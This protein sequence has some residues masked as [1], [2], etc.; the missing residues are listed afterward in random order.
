MTTAAS[1]VNAELYAGH[2]AE[3]QARY[4]EA[5]VR[6]DLDAVV[7]G[8]G[9]PLYRFLDDQPYRYVAN[10]L[11]RHWVPLEEHPGSAIVCKPGCRP[12]LIVHQPLDFW[13][14]PPPLPD[15]AVAS[16]FELRIMR[17]V[18]EL[19]DLLPAADGNRLALLGAA[20]QWEGIAPEALRNPPALLDYLHYH[21]ARKS[22][23]ELGCLRAA[24]A[25][26]TAGHQAAEEAFYGGGSEFDILFAF[27]RGCGQTEEELPYGLIVALDEHGA[28]LHYQ[29]R[30]RTRPPAGKGLSLLIDAGCSHLGYASDITRSHARHDGEF[31][32]MV[33][34]MTTLQRE[35]CNAVRPGVPFADLH[36]FAH[37]GIAGLLRQWGIVRMA[38]EDMVGSGITG[39]FLP[40]GLGH[41][42]GLQVHD[43]GGHLADDSGRELAPPADF[44][45]LRLR[46]TLEPGQVVTIEPGVYFIDSLLDEL[47]SG[48][49]ANQVD[50]EL[51]GRLHRYGGIR[52]EDDLL[53]TTDGHENLTRPLPGS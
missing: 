36:R 35:I 38:P 16:R 48:P 15:D 14:R 46:R 50:W 34:D 27:L 49:H 31:A 30:E 2:V 39:R 11:F 12:L 1:T 29:H 28:S 18:S 26:A 19:P 6:F 7:I 21:R 37:Q 32:D 22:R 13:H 33:A 51:I 17:N 43:V 53:I 23:W 47:R 8:S 9:N 4:E 3:L 24:A 42:L 45:K 25:L 20:E 52:I 5:A 10:P 41:F 40:H 44:P